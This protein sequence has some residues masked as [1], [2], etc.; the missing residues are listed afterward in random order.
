MDNWIT[1]EKKEVLVTQ[2]FHKPTSRNCKCYN[3]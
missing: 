3:H 1:V 2:K